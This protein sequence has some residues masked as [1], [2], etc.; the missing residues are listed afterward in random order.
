MQSAP[1]RNLGGLGVCFLPKAPKEE[2]CELSCS[3]EA[4]EGLGGPWVD[5]ICLAAPALRVWGRT[6]LGQPSPLWGPGSCGH[7]GLD[8]SP[9]RAP[10][11]AQVVRAPG[12]RAPSPACVSPRGAD[13]G[14]FPAAPA[15]APRVCVSQPGLTQHT[16]LSASLGASARLSCT[17]SSAYSG[18]ACALCWHEQKSGGPPQ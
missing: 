15:P 18:G 16:S 5:P 12:S 3:R 7:R 4:Q 2:G 13:S 10:L 1:G 8:S 9:A 17:L 6:G 11:S 14:T